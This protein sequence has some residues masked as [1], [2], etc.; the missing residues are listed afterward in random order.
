MAKHIIFDENGKKISVRMCVA[1][2]QSKPKDALIR[3]AKPAGGSVVVDTALTVQ[4]RG[5]YVCR[6]RSCI[7]K[8]QKEGLI[9]RS[10]KTNIPKEIYEVLQGFEK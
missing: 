10:L 8:S 5:A 7:E 9:Q 6:N 3:V 1:C 2:R 4:G